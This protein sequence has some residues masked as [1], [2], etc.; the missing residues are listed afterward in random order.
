MT[1]TNPGGG[2]AIP[3]SIDTMRTVQGGAAIP[4]Y[5]YASAPTDGRPAMAGAAIPVR[6]LTAADLKENGGTWTLEGR[7][8]ALPVYTAPAT[9]TVM[10][11]PA[12]AVYPINAWPPV[13]VPPT[14]PVSDDPPTVSSGTLLLGL[15]A[16]KLT[17]ADGDAVSTWA[18]Q[19]GNS[20]DFTQSGTARPVYH[21]TGGVSYV[22]FDGVD[23]WMDG[24]NWAVLDNLPSMTVFQVFDASTLGGSGMILTK[25][26]NFGYEDPGDHGYGTW[27]TGASFDTDTSN[28]FNQ[29]CESF[30]PG[31]WSITTI[32]LVNLT[33]L[34]IYYNGTLNNQYLPTGTIHG[35]GVSEYSNS[36]TLKLGTDNPNGLYEGF[37]AV[38]LC[39][40]MAYA[41][42]LNATDRNAVTAWLKS[43]Y[44]VQLTT[45]SFVSAEI[46]SATNGTV[47]VRFTEQVEG[48]DYT[49]GVTIKKNGVAQ[50]ISSATRIWAQARIWYVIP[51]ALSTDTI[52]FEYSKSSGNMVTKV[53]GN[54]VEDIAPQVATNYC[55]P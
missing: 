24:Q 23:D 15:L 37:T 49:A 43:K 53:S 39:A 5:G 3:V 10:G 27:D 9:A 21:V 29:R 44:N 41:P 36:E 16:H 8:Y 35:T 12:L 31:L 20:R 2:A 19:S 55:F 34:N 48:A 52:T 38:K 26:N 32:E 45:A 47:V 42:A 7:P 54:V 25:I 30:P 11:G 46:G 51:D 4:V 22:E 28:Y 40:V 33:T 17:F 50:A 13:P 14:P 6:V 1:A 18:D